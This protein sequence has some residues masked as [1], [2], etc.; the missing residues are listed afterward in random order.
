MG[1]RLAPLLIL[2]FQLP[3]GSPSHGYCLLPCPLASRFLGCFLLSW[4]EIFSVA[5]YS[6]P[7]SQ[8]SLEEAWICFIGELVFR[9]QRTE[10]SICQHWK[11]RL[12]QQMQSRCQPMHT[13][14][15]QGWGSNDQAARGWRALDC[16][17]TRR[18]IL[19]P[20]ELQTKVVGSRPRQRSRRERSPCQQHP[21]HIK[22]VM[23]TS[24]APGKLAPSLDP[25]RPS[26][27][28]RVLRFLTLFLESWF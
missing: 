4:Q 14:D 18:Q 12:I 8:T 26:V 2:V 28:F 11:W 5:S 20:S 22:D 16:W 6:Q 15:P 25:E 24:Q 7:W 21:R 17:R 19:G 3:R 10:C 1:Q 27:L 9:N 13:E 23:W